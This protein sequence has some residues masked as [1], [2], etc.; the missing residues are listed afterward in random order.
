VCG[1]AGIIGNGAELKRRQLDSML[2]SISHR[3]PD[4]SGVYIQN[5]LAIGHQRLSILDR[6]SA[7]KNPFFSNNGDFIIVYNGEVYNY[8]ELRDQL[9]EKY[10][11]KTE[12]DT[13]VVLAAYIIWG[14]KCVNKF[15]GMFSFVIYDTIRDLVFGS[16]D[17]FGIKPFYYTFY[18]DLFYFSSEIKGFFSA[19]IGASEN[20][21]I[22]NE[23]LQY[24]L[25]DHCSKTFF[26]GIEK[27]LPGH[28]FTLKNGK[29]NIFQYWDLSEYE[30]N[31]HYSD[32]Y[33]ENRVM[34][35]LTDSVSISM[36]S[37]VNVGVNLSG[38]LDSSCLLDLINK[39]WNNNYNLLGFT[40]DY[41]DERFSERRWVEK[42]AKNNDR[43]IHFSKMTPEDF[44]QANANMMWYQDE[45]YAGVPVAGY[46]GMYQKTNS[47]NVTVLLDGNGLDEAFAGYK[48]HHI[49]FL[50]DLYINR[51]TSFDSHLK[52][53]IKEWGGSDRDVLEQLK[54]NNLGLVKSR[55]GTKEINPGFLSQDFL[56]AF[57]NTIATQPLKNLKSHLKNSMYRD[58]TYS[59]IPRAL[60]FNDRVSMA[61]SKELRV[62]FLDHRLFEFSFSLNNSLLYSQKRPKGVIRKI[63]T[64]SLPGE[65]VSATKRSVQTPQ[66]EW[67]NNDLRHWVLN[68][69]HSKSFKERG[70]FDVKNVQKQYGK[71]KGQQLE[72]SFQIWQ[73]VNLELW[74]QQN[75]DSK[76]SISLESNFPTF[77]Q[78]EFN[79]K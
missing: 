9:K 52:S 27:I 37:D 24:G 16:R 11:F 60:R 48:Q 43:S 69:I 62:P 34:E 71:L 20:L 64:N 12:T 46:V 30:S 26:S 53:Y 13:E 58:A 10:R 47:Q 49:H 67:L 14:E 59:K 23:Y 42:I 79:I 57:P 72:N 25:Y 8:L 4:D 68:I 76:P 78:D 50:K 66:S 39:N 36:R 44:Q 73:M 21:S 6:S 70:I 75:I 19:G 56:G 35:I 7:G 32:A 41:E 61:F 15:I 22:V 51:D 18:K 54:Q 40:Q 65:I 5:N 63:F 29:L 17:R 77:K 1:I 38:G 74:F 28:S 3:G 33:V 45:P 31:E 2:S 55:D